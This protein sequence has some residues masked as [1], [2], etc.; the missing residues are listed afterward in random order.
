[1]KNNFSSE[2]GQTL[3]IV[4]LVM[5]VALTIG[6]SVASRS[7]VNLRATSEE[8]NSQLAFSA[9]EAGVERVLKTGTN[10]TNIS[11]GN[12]DASIKSANATT[13]GQNEFIV[14]CGNDASLCKT[15]PPVFKDDGVDIWLSK[16][17]DYTDPLS[18]QVF[19]IY[20]GTQA[21]NCGSTPP[22]AAIEVIVISGSKAV[23]IST[24]YV[25]D[26]CSRGNKFTVLNQSD[27]GRF[28]VLGKTFKYKTPNNNDKIAITS[29][30][31]ARIVPLYANTPIAVSTCDNGGNNGNGNNNNNNNNGNGNNGNGNSC[32]PLPSQGQTITSIGTAGETVR[33]IT[34]YQGY[35]ELPSEFFQHI[36]FLA[37]P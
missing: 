20:W 35:P 37:S 6:L 2:S 8:A 25:Y 9:A 28:F 5:V 11:L 12:N 26:P 31:I 24:R 13:I 17:P 21:D 7:I 3:L 14:N 23:P 27:I 32:T 33:K 4:V 34:Y 36:L 1:M 22:P 16:Y 30:L 19:T 29:G 18:P 10:I 15:I